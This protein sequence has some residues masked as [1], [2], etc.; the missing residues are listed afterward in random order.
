MNNEFVHEQAAGLAKRLIATSSAEIER[1][2]TAYRL[3]LGRAADD[4]ERAE[5]VEFLMD[6]R[7]AFGETDRSDDAREIAIWA[8]F[9]RTLLTRNEF[10]FVD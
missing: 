9:A 8:S 5:A 7:A 10:L 3:T 4:D 1:I 6:Y 2:H